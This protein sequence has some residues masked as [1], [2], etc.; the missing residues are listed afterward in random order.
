MI[1]F[2]KFNK[3]AIQAHHRIA[4]LELVTM[5][6]LYSKNTKISITIQ[7]DGSEIF[8]YSL[9]HP[10]KYTRNRNRYT[11]EYALKGYFSTKSSYEYLNDI[12]AR[13]TLSMKVL[14]TDISSTKDT[15]I[16]LSCFK[17]LKS[18][19]RANNYEKGDRG[20][21]NVFW[22]IK[23]YTEDLIRQSGEGN[24]IAYS[25]LESFAF[26]RFIERAK[27]KSTLKAKCRGIWNWY[28]ERDWT[29]PTRQGKGM[30]RADGARIAHKKL[31]ENTKKKVLNVITGI[32]QDE[33]KN[34]KGKWNISKIAKD[35]KTARGTVM[36]YI[37]E[38]ENE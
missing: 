13:F 25:L 1:Q 26:S 14:S 4:V 36:K 33:Y 3:K 9:P 23:L 2:G 10:I 32:F 34:K 31:A 37:K 6:K 28:D 17:G 30:S 20:E 19:K 15:G 24:L 27:D 21:D 7:G 22:S 11:L 35:S 16:E 29:I 18:I 5:M 38:Y 12:I 8:D